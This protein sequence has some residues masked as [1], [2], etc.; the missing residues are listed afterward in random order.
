MCAGLSPPP[1]PAWPLHGLPLA[2]PPAGVGAAADAGA[3]VLA[4]HLPKGPRTPAMPSPAFGYQVLHPGR[5][6]LPI[7]AGSSSSAMVLVLRHGCAPWRR[8]M[9]EEPWP[10][11]LFIILFENGTL[12]LHVHGTPAATCQSRPVDPPSL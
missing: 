2:A 6:L 5:R 12:G 8:T 3:A 4:T 10:G 7:A 1:N 9:L 11:S